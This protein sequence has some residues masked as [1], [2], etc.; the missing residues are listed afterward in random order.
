MFKETAK[1]N[2]PIHQVDAPSYTFSA[3]TA[4]AVDGMY[5]VFDS[6]SLDEL[7]GPMK[8]IENPQWMQTMM[9]P[10][11]FVHIA[12]SCGQRTRFMP[13]SATT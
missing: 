11:D 7:L 5:F 9:L 4:Q 6:I 3:T 10:I 8:A 13:S 2:E 12:A 1:S